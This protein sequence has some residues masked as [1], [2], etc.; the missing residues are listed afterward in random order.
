MQKIFNR[1]DNR[2]INNDN[3]LIPSK[4]A[5]TNRIIRKPIINLVEICIGIQ[6]IRFKS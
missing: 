2:L 1:A 5:F 6:L 3:R 4:I